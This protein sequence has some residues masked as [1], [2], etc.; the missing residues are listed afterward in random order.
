MNGRFLLKPFTGIGQYTINLIKEL[1]KIDGEKRYLVFVP[2][3]APT[4]T[5]AREEA[6]AEPEAGRGVGEGMSAKSFPKNVEI[7]ILP[8]KKFPSAGARKVWWE[9]IQLPEALIKEGVEL[10]Y[11]PY[12]ANPWAKD[13]YKKNIRIA[14]TV[15]DCLP[16]KYKHYT[17]GILSR[18]IHAQA[19]KAVNKADIVFT[20]SKVSKKEIIDICGV[21]GKKVFVVYNDASDIFKKPADPHLTNE[22]LAKFGLQQQ[23]FFFYCGGYDER[24]NVP[25]LLRE[26]DLFTRDYEEDMPLVLAG[27]KALNSDLYKSFDEAKSDF[28]EIIKTGFLK[29]YEL[30]I[31]Y[32]NCLAFVNLSRE[33]GFNI[34]LVEAANCG[35][36]LIISDTE[37]H[38]EIA[39]DHGCFVDIQ[40]EGVCGV[41]MGKMLDFDHRKNYSAKAK[42]LA[43]KY[44]WKISAQRVYDVLF[45]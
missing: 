19:K 4:R 11:F 5:E 9:Q 24:K 16:W 3:E 30:K 10:A 23:R 6:G 33:E 17:G 7:K 18:M 21:D 44:S 36:P 35:A 41:A 43:K 45:S 25:K 13:F 15:H 31:L 26:Y 20:V 22:V 29:E 28:G 34:P 27:G 32:E 14:V 8:E 2:A 39:G 38:R 1:A 37:I 42:E 12:P 40:K